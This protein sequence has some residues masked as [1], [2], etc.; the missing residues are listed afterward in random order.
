M[1]HQKLAISGGLGVPTSPRQFSGGKRSATCRDIPEGR[2]N[3]YALADYELAD[4]WPGSPLLRAPS[5]PEVPR[6]A[7]IEQELC[8]RRGLQKQ[9][10]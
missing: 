7:R 1:V 2:I 6:H 5:K 4:S 10:S 8:S 9:G 3:Q